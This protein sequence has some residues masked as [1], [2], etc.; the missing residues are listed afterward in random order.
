MAITD[1]IAVDF[2][3]EHLRTNADALG[4][5]YYGSQQLRQRWD[6]LGA[7]VA[8]VT[9]KPLFGLVADLHVGPLGAFQRCHMTVCG[10]RAIN[11]GSMILSDPAEVFQDGAPADG[12]QAVNG[13]QARQLVQRIRFYENWLITGTFSGN[14]DPTGDG[15]RADHCLTVCFKKSA[16]TQA[17]VD[18]LLLRYD[19]WVAECE[20]AS[21]AVLNVI[22]AYAVN[23]QFVLPETP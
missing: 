7:P 3:N 8:F 21:N 14:V 16:S 17:E 11:A 19:E 6:A 18:N 9:L 23:P 22:L 2:S 12:R 15:L 5:A 1:P 20:A 10:G 4:K 13:Q